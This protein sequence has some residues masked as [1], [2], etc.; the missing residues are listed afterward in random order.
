[1]MRAVRW[2]MVT[3]ACMGLWGCGIFQ[4]EGPP[5]PEE[6]EALALIEQLKQVNQGLETFKGIG[7]MRFQSPEGGGTFR[8][9]W[10]GT[11]D[12]RLRFELRSVTGQPILS[13]AAD[14]KWFYTLVHSKDRLDRR[15]MTSNTKLSIPHVS[16]PLKVI[17]IVTYL[18]GGVPLCPHHTAQLTRSNGENSTKI[19]PKASLKEPDL[20]LTLR[21]RL[22]RVCERVYLRASDMRPH[23]VELYDSAYNLAYRVGVSGLLQVDGYQLPAALRF[24]I[25]QETQIDLHIERYWANP[26]LSPSFFVLERNPKTG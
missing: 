24:S 2:L 6:I 26:A 11:S 5:T 4:T 25:D 18:V 7:R 23:R 10:G 22:G 3:I 12:G 8:A 15:R 13:L 9:Y 20:V 21:K 14:G 16:I 17:D 19:Q 1:M